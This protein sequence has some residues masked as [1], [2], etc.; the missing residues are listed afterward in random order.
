[1]SRTASC[2]WRVLFGLAGAGSALF[3]HFLPA[4]ADLGE[5]APPGSAPAAVASPGPADR[6]LVAVP[7][8]RPQRGEPAEPARAP[9]VLATD[10]SA[11][12][13]PTATRR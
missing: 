1:M 3:V 2:L 4:P 6:P 13:P 7:V 8:P 10:G 5:D 9:A 12:R 11:S